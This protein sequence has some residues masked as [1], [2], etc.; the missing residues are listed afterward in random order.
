MQSVT[1]NAVANELDGLSGFKFYCVGENGTPVSV[2]KGI[3]FYGSGSNYYCRIF[4]EN[5]TVYPTN[6]YWGDPASGFNKIMIGF[7]KP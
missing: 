4:T 7:Y 6:G 2:S 3:F 5:A 1:S